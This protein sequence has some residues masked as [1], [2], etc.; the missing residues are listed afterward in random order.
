MSPRRCGRRQPTFWVLEGD[1]TLEAG[2]RT[3]RAGAG[4][5][6]FGPRGIPHRDPV[7]DAGCR[8]LFILTSRGFEGLVREMSA[9]AASRTLP[10]PSD[11]EP[12][13]EH[14]AAGARAHGCAL[15]G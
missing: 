7:G 14:V 15:L 10:P 4:D 13:W 5:V 1:V 6:A 2:D 12:D 8:M 11:E 9:P 3:I